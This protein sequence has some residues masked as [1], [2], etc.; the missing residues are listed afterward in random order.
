MAWDPEEKDNAISNL[1][2]AGLDPNYSI[3]YLGIGQVI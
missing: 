1:F 2:L 3:N